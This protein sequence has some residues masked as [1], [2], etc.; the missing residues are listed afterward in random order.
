MDDVYVKIDES[1]GGSCSECGGVVRKYYGNVR[2]APS[3]T[4]TR[5]NV[6]FDATSSAE[7]AKVRDMAAYKRLRGEGLQPPAINGSANLESKAGT[8]HEINS[9]MLLKD[10]GRKRKEKALNDV[11]GSG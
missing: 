1:Y 9:G 2:L 6:N 7:K 11:L 5:S 8:K 10:E 3:V 4:P